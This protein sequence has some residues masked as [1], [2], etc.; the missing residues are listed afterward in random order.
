MNKI[1]IFD[2]VSEAKNK[3]DKTEIRFR[4]HRDALKS[5]RERVWD[6][7]GPAPM[8][9]ILGFAPHWLIM[10]LAF[11]VLFCA[12]TVVTS[13]GTILGLTLIAFAIMWVGNKAF[14][15]DYFRQFGQYKKN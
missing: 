13:I 1:N 12:V 5:S 7:L 2:D 15:I 8:G 4:K 14:D 6:V 9:T 10:A 11:L 3:F